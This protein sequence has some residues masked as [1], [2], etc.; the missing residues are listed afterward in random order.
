MPNWSIT[1]SGLAKL[2]RMKKVFRNF[3]LKHSYKSVYSVGSYSTF[4]SWQE[5]MGGLGFVQDVATGMPVPSCPY[6]IS[7]VS[8]NEAFSPLLGVDMT[9]QNG[10]TAKAEYRRTRVLTLSMTSQQIN[11][12][13]SADW[14]FGVG[15]KIN[16][17]KLF[18]PKKTVRAK[19]RGSKSNNKDNENRNNNSAASSSNAKGFANTFNVRLDISFRDQSALN[20]DIIAGFSQ[21]TSGNKAVQVSFSAEY[22]LSRYLTLSAYYDRQK[23]TPLLTSNSYP[24]ITQDF[25]INL[26]FTLNR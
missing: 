7:T 3:N 18:V 15:Y 4:S 2:P 24:T 11:E 22:A 12:T 26:K 17:L 9:L 21:A 19:G 14:V 6:D 16:D 20:R 8:V 13:R 25:G 5:Y 23:N 10:I 1:Y